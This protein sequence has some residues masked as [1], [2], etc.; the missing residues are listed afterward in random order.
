MKCPFR[1]ETHQIGDYTFE[2]FGECYGKECPYFGKEQTKHR[3]EGGFETVI[4]PICRR[5]EEKE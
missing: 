1:K 5:C 2:N 4:L 3:Y